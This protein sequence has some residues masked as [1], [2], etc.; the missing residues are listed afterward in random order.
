MC[1]CQN[2]SS[3]KQENPQLMEERVSSNSQAA[4]C[5]K[6]SDDVIQSYITQYK[7]LK[8][9]EIKTKPELT[10]SYIDK[11]IGNLENIMRRKKNIG[12]QLFCTK[13][14]SYLDFI[15]QELNNLK[16]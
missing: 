13:Y 14:F 15:E 9:L 11:K 5:S 7:L 10:K 8:T 12:N 1:G 2:N 16:Y 6:Y 3:V 4:Q